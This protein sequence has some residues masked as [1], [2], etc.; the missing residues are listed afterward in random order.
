MK[1]G[2]KHT[3]FNFLPASRATL[4]KGK[5]SSEA[6]VCCAFIDR[7]LQTIGF[8]E[9]KPHSVQVGLYNKER[10]YEKSNTTDQAL[11]GSRGAFS[12]VIN[13]HEFE[14]ISSSLGKVGVATCEGSSSLLV[15]GPKNKL[16]IAKTVLRMFLDQIA[17]NRLNEYLLSGS[18]SFCSVV[19]SLLGGI[20]DRKN[21]TYRVDSD[22]YVA[23][24]QMID[25]LDSKIMGD[26][27]FFWIEY[28]RSFSPEP[29][30]FCFAAA[31]S[32]EELRKYAPT[33][34]TDM[35]RTLFL[36]KALHMNFKHSEASEANLGLFIDLFISFPL[37]IVF[38]YS[39]LV[40]DYLNDQF[41]T[42]LS[43]QYAPSEVDSIKK[44][45][46]PHRT[47]KDSFLGPKDGLM[48]ARTPLKAP[49]EDV[50]DER[51]RTATSHVTSL[52]KHLY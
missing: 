39:H 42:E 50:M 29:F 3:D 47:S 41:L 45:T 26:E 5:T 13:T 18:D 36:K 40:R 14:K 22:N 38:S 8:L 7:E 23:V 31:R 51:L 16:V 37:R 25:L 34:R 24:A 6:I 20:V 27:F 48:K 9:G 17:S 35:E 15:L 46:S 30:V 4:A 49:K 1:G 52:F 43:Q 19:D 21:N 10:T 11:L 33:K 32:F 2:G 28:R 12:L 44:T